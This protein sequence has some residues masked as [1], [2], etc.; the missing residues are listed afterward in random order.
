MLQVG[1][2]AVIAVGLAWLGLALFALL[3]AN[4]MIFPAPPSSYSDSSSIRRFSINERGDSIA[5]LYLQNVTARYLVFYHHGNGEDLGG[6]IDR[7][8]TLRDLGFAVLAWDYPGYGTSDGRP[9]ETAILRIAEQIWQDIPASYGFPP[10]RILLYGRS[11]GG[12]PATWLAGRQP[13][14]G[15]ILEGTFTST[16]RVMTRVRL[17]PWDV[18]DNL[19]RIGR[20]QC[21]V[22]LLHGTDDRV[23]PFH[24]SQQLLAA[25]QSPKSFTW[26]DGGGHND[27][28]DAFPGIYRD[29]IRRFVQRLEASPPAAP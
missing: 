17:L 1:K 5:L 24:H 16:F 21:P 10:E 18:F 15:L 12:G 3:M 14:A 20:V 26:F 13:A 11:L 23:V 29:S 25:A 28:P 6:I 22:L 8:R 9:S 27:L 4:R 19:G 2:A 7:L